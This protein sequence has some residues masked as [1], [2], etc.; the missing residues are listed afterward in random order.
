MQTKRPP[1]SNWGD[2]GVSDRRGRL[3]E[4]TPKRVRRAAEEIRTGLRFC[5][6]LPLDLPGGN[7]L[8]PSRYP[9]ER[10]LVNR[11]G[12]LAHDF[13]LSL[14][15]EGA[16]GV[17]NDDIVVLY[18]QYS[19]Q[20][21]AFSHVGSHF[22]ANGDGE[23]EV[24]YY[25]AMYPGPDVEEMAAA[26]IAG[27]GVMID[28]H[29]AFGTAKTYVTYKMLRQAMRD[30]DV[31][32]KKGDVLALHTGFGQL[33]LDMHGNPDRETLHNS[34]AGLD[35]SDPELLE[36]VTKSGV[37]ALVS[38]NFAVEGYP[39]RVR[40]AGKPF[41]PLHEHCLFKLGVHLGEIW[42]LTELAHWL[43]RNGRCRFFLA[44]PPLRLR[45]HVG[46]PANPIAI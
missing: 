33:I 22:D 16:T 31:T 27:R 12:R 19:T 6:S 23:A 1:G 14:Q 17:V 43:E 8:H 20:W 32:V 25:N 11:E 9:P 3:N 36:W 15:R 38:D 41:L 26:C 5:L 18:T 39:A 4:L 28:L 44:A 42:Y 10:K 37:V 29:R 21:D 40:D 45:G 34:C 30:Q 46:S 13:P 35:G 2:Y 7:I 24:I